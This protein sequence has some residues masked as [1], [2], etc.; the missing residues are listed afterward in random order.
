MQDLRLILFIIGTIFIIGL[1]IHGLWTSRKERS[2]IFRDKPL[3]R[4]RN[5]QNKKSSEE[6]PGYPDDGVGKVRIY[7]A[8]PEEQTDTDLASLSP[9]QYPLPYAPLNTNDHDENQTSDASQPAA[10]PGS[11]D[12]SQRPSPDNR[13]ENPQQPPAIIIL[14]VAAHTGHSFQGAPLLNSILQ[15]GFIFGEMNIFHRHLTTDGNGPILF[16]LANMIK[17][18]IFEPEQMNGFTTPGVTLFMQIPGY[19][20]A[21][22]NFKLMLQSAQQLAE[23]LGGIVQDDQR[24]LITPEKLSE[25]QNRVRSVKTTHD[26]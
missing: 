5:R 19:G 8:N 11:S 21:V 14:N 13:N 18:G 16:S 2:S 10:K 17:P 3:K 9:L 25:Y 1:L 22:Q 4:M 12:T 7:P 23:E 24:H 26:V 20:D 15:A 6:M